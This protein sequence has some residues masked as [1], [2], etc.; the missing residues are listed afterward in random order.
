M[1]PALPAGLVNSCG[2]SQM[3]FHHHE[4]HQMMT[5]LLM[6]CLMSQRSCMLCCKRILIQGTIEERVLGKGILSSLLAKWC[7]EALDDDSCGCATGVCQPVVD[8]AGLH[9]RKQFS[10]LMFSA[11]V[12]FL[13]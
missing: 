1:G 9:A 3:S 13:C 6:A 11:C 8:D 5:M 2:A 4:C 10:K 12:D 7:V